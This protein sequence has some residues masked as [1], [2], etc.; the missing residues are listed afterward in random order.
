MIALEDAF[1]Q[2]QS[3][4]ACVALRSEGRSNNRREATESE[5][6]EGMASASSSVVAAAAAADDANAEL[7][8]AAI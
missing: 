4:Q 6:V 8:A 1:G 2:K 7:P 5:Q 3:H